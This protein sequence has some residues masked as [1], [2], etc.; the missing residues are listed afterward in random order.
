MSQSEELIGASPLG[1]DNLIQA[2]IYITVLFSPPQLLTP[3]TIA[4]NADIYGLND[5]RILSPILRLKYL[6]WPRV[7]AGMLLRP[8]PER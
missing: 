7:R 5:R 1:V 6:C 3:L 2:S 4:D 8:I